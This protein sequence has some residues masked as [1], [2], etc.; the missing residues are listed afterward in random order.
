[1]A[2]FFKVYGPILVLVLL[3]FLAAYQFVDP[4][5]PHQLTIA[6]GAEGGAYAAYGARYRDLL[7]PEGIEVTLV[8]SRGSVENL[9]LLAADRAE[10]DGP[11]VDIAFVQSG[12]GTPGE[13]PQLVALASLYFEPLWVFSRGTEAP[14]SLT[15]LAGRRLAVGAAGSGTRHV[16]LQLL[17]ANGIGDDDGTKIDPLGSAKALAA[18]QLGLVDAAFL[19]TAKRSAVLTELLQQQGIQLMSFERAEAYERRF[20]HLSAVVLPE[21]V[22]DL[23]GNLPDHDITLVS[24]LATLVAREDVHP[25]LIDLVMRAASE[26]H[27]GPGLFEDA[28]Q[29]PSP[30][31]VNFPLSPEAERYFKSGLGFLHR[32]L[33]FWAATFIDRTWILIL[34]VLTL[35]IPLMRI[36]P[37]TYRW[38]VRRRIFRWYRDLRRLETKLQDAT[39]GGDAEPLQEALADIGSLQDEVG[40]VMVPLS[41]A[42]NL[43]H[44]RLHIDFVRRRYEPPSET[45]SSQ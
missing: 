34:P 23:A 22:L 26:I 14:G 5:P 21:G 32:V 33:P 41:Y 40:Q 20:P 9:S 27:G 30:Q 16:A 38:Q 3:G 42:D 10:S 37:P 35:L 39:A 24:P 17:A 15:E 28:G 45:L 4:A 29:F 8:A 12:I 6:T 36:A 43:Y 11:S 1:M 13:F 7:A 19:V 44:L 2:D 31:N 18:L 25:A